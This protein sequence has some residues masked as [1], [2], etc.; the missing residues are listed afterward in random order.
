MISTREAKFIEE[1]LLDCNGARAAVAAGYAGGNSAKVTA[2]RL[3][4]RANVQ[5]ALETCRATDR[6]RLK[7][8]RETVLAGVMGAIDDAKR[9]DD[10]SAQIAGWRELAKLLGLYEPV[11]AAVTLSAPLAGRLRAMDG[12]TD[13][14]LLMLAGTTVDS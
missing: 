14:E 2:C 8:D 1:Y 5:T 13:S 12:L 10:P 11:R 7:I 4:T 9:K 3:L 6:E